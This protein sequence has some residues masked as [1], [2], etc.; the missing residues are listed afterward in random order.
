MQGIFIN[1]MRPKFKKDV[2]AYVE[3][4]NLFLEHGGDP[5]AIQQLEALYRTR[6]LPKDSKV[7]M[8]QDPF[9]LVIE[10]TSMFGNEF[11][12]S[13]AKATRTGLHGPFSIVGPDPRTSRKWYLTIKYNTDT[14]EWEVK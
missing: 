10:A 2:V 11:D 9:G 4:V 1:G 6:S 12:G 13:L 3:G 5:E 14:H 8:P 7:I